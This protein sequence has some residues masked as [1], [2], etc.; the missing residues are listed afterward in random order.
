MNASKRITVN[1]KR[2]TKIGL[3]V[4]LV[5]NPGLYRIRTKDDGM[6]VCQSCTVMLQKHVQFTMHWDCLFW[7]NAI[8]K[9]FFR[10][11]VHALLQILRIKWVFT[12]VIRSTILN[13]HN[14]SLYKMQVNCKSLKKNFF[15]K[16]AWFQEFK[17]DSI[18][19]NLLI[20]HP[21]I[22]F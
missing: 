11:Q 6:S 4:L 8:L 5:R 17:D 14:S 13:P 9:S 7:N 3:P 1:V 22:K 21:E 12:S 20:C 10:P 19:E 15:N 16:A 18:L 2:V